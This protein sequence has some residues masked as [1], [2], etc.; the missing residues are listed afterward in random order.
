M[1]M[2]SQEFSRLKLLWPYRHGLHVPVERWLNTAL[3]V[4]LQDQRDAARKEFWTLVHMALRRP[5]LSVLHQINESKEDLVSEFL[6]FGLFKTEST[7][8]DT[9]PDS[10]YKLQGYF[11]DFLRDIRERR[12]KLVQYGTSEEVE[13]NHRDALACSHGSNCTPSEPW[14]LDEDAYRQSAELFVNGLNK[15]HLVLL[16]HS[17]C[18]E[19]SARLVEQEYSSIWNPQ[20]AHAL[21]QHRAATL[22]ATLPHAKTDIP[23]S[24]FQETEI[25]A[26]MR[27]VL[28]ISPGSTQWHDSIPALARLLCDVAWSEKHVLASKHLPTGNSSKKQVSASPK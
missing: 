19:K 3:Q 24:Y 5:N 20:A 23:P 22:G 11:R 15:Y 8:Y 17:F 25:G 18:H 14:F 7:R 9:P 12:S 2:T 28:A 1:T 16:Q 21:S 10:Q 4:T 27:C 13:E 6:V 26:W